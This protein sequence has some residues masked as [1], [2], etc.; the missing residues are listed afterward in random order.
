[1]YF[2]DATKIDFFIVED[3]TLLINVKFDLITDLKILQ[4]KVTKTLF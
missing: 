4:I 2:E 1:M 3:T